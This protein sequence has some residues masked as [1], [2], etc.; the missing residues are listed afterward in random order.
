MK[1]TPVEKIPH[2]PREIASLFRGGRFYDSSSSP[3]AR[4]WLVEG[5]EAFF[6]K[7][8]VRGSLA[9]EA[10]MGAY[11]ASLGL[12]PAV[13][14]YVTEEDCDAE[15]GEARG[16][17][18]LVTERARGE[19]CTAREYLEDPRRLAAVLGETLRSLHE[20]PASG[21]PVPHRM[22]AYFQTVEENFRQGKGDL[23]LFG[24]GVFSSLD[25]AYRTFCEG[26]DH[27]RDEVLIHGDYCLPNVLLEDFRFSAFVDVGMGG[28]GDRHVDLF[29]G[30]WTLWYNLKTNAYRERF[31]DAYGRDGF[32]RNLLLTVAAAEVF[33]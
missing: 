21:C 27:L 24:E 19:D 16:E 18:W 13:V 11:F 22:E 12:S 2:L 29:W 33:G 9:R 10:Q 20:M 31:F 28:I 4:V 26:R 14:A 3:E 5:K 15:N 6:L 25:E 32:D 23:T 7:R 30:A 1:R 8:G 17:D